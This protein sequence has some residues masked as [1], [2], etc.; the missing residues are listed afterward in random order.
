M[1]INARGY[2]NLV[3]T[4]IA[5]LLLVLAL[6]RPETAGLGR[7][8]EAATKERD[9]TFRQISEDPLTAAAVQ[10]LAKANLEIAEQTGAV[11]KAIEGIAKAIGD[12]ARATK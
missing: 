5:V 9:R 3:L 7:S 12:H 10:A 4:A 1:K 11:A 6:G 8:A 2:T